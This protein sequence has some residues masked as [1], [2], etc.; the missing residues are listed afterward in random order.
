MLL[1]KLKNILPQD[2]SEY[3]KDFLEIIQNLYPTSDPE[4]NIVIYLWDAYCFSKN[5]HDGQLRRSGKPYFTHCASVGVI[6]SEWKMDSKTIAA[7]LMH[8]VI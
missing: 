3:T 4:K 6:L 7:G 1:E 5:A 8:D 2:G